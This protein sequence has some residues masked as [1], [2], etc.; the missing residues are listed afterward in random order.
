MY[1]KGYHVMSKTE[2]LAEQSS[3]V[4]L[5]G[6]II[7]CRVPSQ[8]LHTAGA[9]EPREVKGKKVGDAVEWQT[10]SNGDQIWIVGTVNKGGMQ[11]RQGSAVAKPQAAK[12]AKAAS[13]GN[14]KVK[15]VSL[16]SADDLG[17]AFEDDWG[18]SAPVKPV[19][20][21]KVIVKP[22]VVAKKG[23]GAVVKPVAAS[24]KGGKYDVPV[25]RAVR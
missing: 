13:R 2:V 10:L 15:A 4:S 23:T 8:I 14:G 17:S 7:R 24:T 18:D 6:D 19:K 1:M 3:D 5:Q 16:K 25:R 11:G 12:P 21:P 20:A 9:E 22:V